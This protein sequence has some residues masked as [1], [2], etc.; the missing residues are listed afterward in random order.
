MRD[1]SPLLYTAI[2]F[3]ISTQSSSNM[4]LLPV[5]TIPSH[6]SQ[7]YD[8]SEQDF[9]RCLAGMTLTGATSPSVN[10]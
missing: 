3:G 4:E 10:R 7:V 5:K 1:E 6:F 9:G 2:F 8:A